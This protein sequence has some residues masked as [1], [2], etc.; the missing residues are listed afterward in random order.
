MGKKR[1]KSIKKYIIFR[2]LFIFMAQISEIYFQR[3]FVLLKFS[4]CFWIFLFPFSNTKHK[5]WQF[6]IR[7]PCL[8]ELNTELEIVYQLNKFSMFKEAHHQT[9]FEE[10]KRENGDD[11]IVWIMQK[12]SVNQ[13]KNKIKNAKIMYMPKI[14]WID[15]I[16]LENYAFTFHEQRLEYS[17]WRY[18]SKPPR[19]LST[20]T[21]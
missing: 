14:I 18:E 12:L 9:V 5:P 1:L 19:P 15:A 8:R 17:R 20:I 21:P 2:L 13:I 7:L 6:Q 3:Q 11:P 4:Q 16:R 10:E